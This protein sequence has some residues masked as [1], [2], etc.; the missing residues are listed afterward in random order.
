MQPQPEIVDEVNFE[1]IDVRSQ[2]FPAS[3]DFFDHGYANQRDDIHDEDGWEDEDDD[4]EGAGDMFDDYMGGSAEPECRQQWSMIPR[5]WLYT[6]LSLLALILPPLV[7]IFVSY[8]STH[9]GCSYY[10]KPY[11]SSKQY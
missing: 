1:E 2:S 10:T 9:L 11:C 7:P 6:M 3:Q 8:T 5:S 4:D